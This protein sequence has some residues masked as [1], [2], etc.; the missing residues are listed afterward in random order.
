MALQEAV[1]RVFDSDGLLAQAVDEF[2]PRAGQT[3]MA[4][5]VA[6]TM[7]HGGALV[8][9]AGTGVG[10]TFAYLIPALLSGE[11]ALVSTATKALQDQLFGRDIPRLLKVLGLPLRVALLKGRSSYLCLHRME[12]ARQSLFGNEAV[13]LR[14]IAQVEAWSLVTRSGDLAEIP[15]LDERSP[16]IPLVTSTR[17]NCLGSR[18]P[19]ASACHVNL[20]RREAMAA[21][22]VVINHH[23]FFADLNVRESGVAEL[24]PSVTSVVFDEAHQLNEIGVQFLGRQM[25]SGQ[26]A[27]FS[28]DLAARGSQLALGV[29]DWRAL[30]E[31]LEASIA[32][33]HQLCGSGARPG[34]RGWSLE[35][36]QGVD[37]QVWQQALDGMGTALAAAQ[38]V[39]THVAEMSPE[40]ALLRD[41]A[42]SLL[43][44][45]REFA[46]PVP[47][48][49]V[50]WMDV[51]QHFRWVQ[52]PLDISQ[53]MQARVLGL[54]VGDHGRKSWIFTSATLGHD[55]KMSLFVESCGLQGAQVLQV[56]SPFDHA[57]QA[58]LYIPRNFPKPNEASHSA[59]VAALVA[60]AATAIG[61]RTLVLTTTLRAMR[62][63]GDALR[64]YFSGDAGL[65]V[66]VQGQ[67]PKRELVERFSSAGTDG[68]KGCILVASASFWEGIDIPGDALQM[69][70]IDKLPFAP[71][72]DPLVQ[73]RAQQL[74]SDG[75][76]PFQHYHVP[77]AAIALKQGAGRLIRRETDRG[78]LVVC[79][80]RLAQMGYGK[81][82]LA[83][84]P[85][86]TRLETE[87]EF[88]AALLSLT[89][90]STTGRSP[91]SGP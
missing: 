58:A 88:H 52:T 73:A 48:G 43:E 17:E 12:S 13:A 35:S 10:K 19:Q 24:L 74:E 41:R 28:R 37:A 11:R 76:N 3:A 15:A 31:S 4:M 65:D 42:D 86:M 16:V 36:P 2:K 90:P 77:Q 83:A 38:E 72:D 33:L 82:I 29:A 53:A 91:T 39:L 21:D 9:E 60:D 80:V 26:L 50:R 68:S 49:V 40:L 63:I 30:V 54:A 8:V 78:L 14:H 5:A 44:S 51:D 69:V 25:G 22:V 1:G 85:P 66:L 46:Q 89:R 59:C 81:K 56:A 64:Q 27:G 20:A 32:A 45:L 84:L 67:S 75:K 6:Q 70:V 71:P 34:R 87:D 23:L 79:D 7:E 47:A 55:A 61:G 18:C 57:A 62:A